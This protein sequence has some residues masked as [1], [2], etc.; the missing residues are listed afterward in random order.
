MLLLNQP[1]LVHLL[2]VPIVRHRQLEARD[3]DPSAAHG[4]VHVH[5]DVAR[6][7]ALRER[8]QELLA[9]LKGPHHVPVPVVERHQCLEAGLDEV[10]V[11]I[12]VG[13]REVGLCGPV[14]IVGFGVYAAN[15]ADGVVAVV[16]RRVA[17]QE[18]GVELKR[19]LV[20]ALAR[21]PFSEAVDGLVPIG[22]LPVVLQE[23]VVARVHLVVVRDAHVLGD[24]APQ[25]ARGIV[26]VRAVGEVFLV[27]ADGLGDLAVLRSECGDLVLRLIRRA[28]LRVESQVH[29]PGIYGLGYLQLVVAGRTLDGVGSVPASLGEPAVEQRG[30]GEDGL[31]ALRRRL[32]VLRDNRAYNGHH[33]QQAD[34]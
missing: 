32:G 34:G 3:G 4:V 7:S 9:Q 10:R 28:G 18:L 31:V 25:D 29:V 8:V 13:Q 30:L 16:G 6:V 23:V 15:A 20:V 26:A 21:H 17:L 1:V 27:G 19:A 33:A 5:T 2:L 11:R 22:A 14:N 12:L 24:E